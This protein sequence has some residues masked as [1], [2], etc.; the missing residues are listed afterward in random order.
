MENFLSGP[1]AASLFFFNIWK[2]FH[3]LYK[4]KNIFRRE[5]AGLKIIRKF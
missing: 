4:R 3:L 1:P 2:L 5:G